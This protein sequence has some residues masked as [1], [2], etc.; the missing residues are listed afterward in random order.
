LRQFEHCTDFR[1]SICSYQH[2]YHNILNNPIKLA[3]LLCPIQ[4]YEQSLKPLL[5]QI[6]ERYNEILNLDIY[7]EKG[8]PVPALVKLVLRAMEQV[9]GRLLGSPVHRTENKNLNVLF[10]PRAESAEEKIQRLRVE[11]A[12]NRRRREEEFAQRHGPR[13]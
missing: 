7:D 6:A 1:V 3:W 11:L 10:G 5:V 12:E 13:D 8:K 4:D 2:W 9:E